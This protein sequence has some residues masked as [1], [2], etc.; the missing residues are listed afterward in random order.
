MKS[1]YSLDKIT[2]LKADRKAYSVYPSF[3]M[4]KAG[5]SIFSPNRAV[6]IENLLISPRNADGFKA[7]YKENSEL[8]QEIASNTFPILS[9]DT[10]KTIFG[11]SQGTYISLK[12]IT[13]RKRIVLTQVPPYL[14]ES[15]KSEYY[16]ISETS[17]SQLYAIIKKFFFIVNLVDAEQKEKYFEQLVS[18][19]KLRRLSVC[20]GFL[21]Y[22]KELLEYIKDEPVF[23]DP[24]KR[25]KLS[26]DFLFLESPLDCEG[27]VE[28]D[29][30]FFID[31]RSRDNSDIILITRSQQ[32]SKQKP[33]AT[34][35]IRQILTLDLEKLSKNRI[36]YDGQFQSASKTVF[37]I[38]NLFPPFLSNR[39]KLLNNFQRYFI[40]RDNPKVKKQYA[41]LKKRDLSYSQLYYYEKSLNFGKTAFHNDCISIGYYPFNS[42]SNGCVLFDI[43]FKPIGISS[44]SEFD[45]FPL[46]KI[47]SGYNMVMK[48]S[49]KAFLYLAEKVIDRRVNIEIYFNL[50]SL[51]SERIVSKGSLSKG[52]CRKERKPFKKKK[53][54]EV[55]ESEYD[56][57]IVFEYE[58]LQS[59]SL[60]KENTDIQKISVPYNRSTLGEHGNK[61]SHKS[62]ISQIRTKPQESTK[63]LNS[64]SDSNKGSKIEASVSKDACKGIRNTRSRADKK[65]VNMQSR[66]SY[67]FIDSLSY[68]EK[69]KKL[70]ASKRERSNDIN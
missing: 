25:I 41:F 29:S 14:L 51:N 21:A 30:T 54:C 38:T 20:E 37:I 34:S 13:G 61:A 4:D 50:L 69:N 24:I 53:P 35:Q 39:K 68:L 49:N 56:S 55:K 10:E 32:E 23:R 67:D 19:T 66:F 47:S 28:Q 58:Q 33:L 1:D 45:Y 2:K 63:V 48:F 5:E 43:D 70:L 8:L 22:R 65:D 52:D 42:N 40:F 44:M 64:K 16:A 62:S 18:E 3:L 31:P 17:G 46:S 59:K 7:F 26:L 57:K 11:L 27:V 36:E 9:F 60:S 12:S 15:A 6:N